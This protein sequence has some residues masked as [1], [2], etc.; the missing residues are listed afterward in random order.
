MNNYLVRWETDIEADSPEEAAK[1]AQQQ[2][3]TNREGYW[4]GVFTLMDKES[5]K[6]FRVDLDIVN[7]KDEESKI[8]EEITATEF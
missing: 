6:Y 1:L 2:Q 5:E 7:E 4:S 3:Q 8:V